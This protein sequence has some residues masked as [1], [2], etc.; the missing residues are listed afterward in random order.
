MSVNVIAVPDRCL[1]RYTSLLLIIERGSA[2]AHFTGMRNIQAEAIRHRMSEAAVLW[3]GGIHQ[4]CT[5]T[6]GS[7]RETGTGCPVSTGPGLF[8]KLYPGHRKQRAKRIRC[9]MPCL[10]IT[11]DYREW[12]RA[13]YARGRALCRFRAY[14]GHLK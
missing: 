1:S 9:R 13:L 4:G 10:Y 5:A 14:G 3:P 11:H 7:T 12:G 6:E 8:H 2:V